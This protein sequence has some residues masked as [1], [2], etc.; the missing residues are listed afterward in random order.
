MDEGVISAGDWDQIAHG[1][2]LLAE[3]PL[4]LRSQATLRRIGKGTVLFRRG[5]RPRFV[6]YVLRG[7]IRLARHTVDGQQI[8]LQRRSAGF[9][10]EASMESK[11]YHCDI[12]SAEDSDVVLFP[13]VRFRD[14][15]EDDQAFRSVWLKSLASEIR[16]LRAQNERLHL[17]KAS[18][19]VL[20]FIETEG[21]N[22]VVALTQTRKA[23]ALELGL[24]HE[25]LY[26]TLA[27]L[28]AKGTI[29]VTGNTLKL[30]R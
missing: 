12:L 24:S 29:S 22:G 20:H 15:L 4:N 26:R 21:R 13:I 17:R 1:H 18:D 9:I 28:V 14:S 10:A 27:V 6:I 16:Q 3:I 25:A 7:E 23:W 30:F 5:G 19:R 8:V 2:P 11:I